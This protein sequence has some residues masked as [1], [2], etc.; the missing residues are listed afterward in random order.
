MNTDK[1][2]QVDDEKIVRTYS[3]MDCGGRCPLREFM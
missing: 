2:N 1:I 3:A